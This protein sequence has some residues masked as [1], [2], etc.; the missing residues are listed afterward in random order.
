M[1]NTKQVNL[2]HTGQHSPLGI[3]CFGHLSF[4]HFAYSYLHLFS[5]EE[6]HRINS[7]T[8]YQIPSQHTKAINVRIPI[9]S[10]TSAKSIFLWRSM[11]SR[12]SAGRRNVEL[13]K[14][15]RIPT[16]R[17]STFLRNISISQLDC[18]EFFRLDIFPLRRAANKGFELSG[19][20]IILVG[21]AFHP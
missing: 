20:K 15:E 8:L 11:I 5:V 13:R 21:V 18:R 16:V 19:S 2:P 3:N 10:D 6:Y 1:N 4:L 14:V 12:I 9:P 7:T 17:G